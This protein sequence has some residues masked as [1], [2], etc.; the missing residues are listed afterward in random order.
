MSYSIYRILRSLL[1]L[2]RLCFGLFGRRS[3]VRHGHEL[4]DVARNFRMMETTITDRRD[5]VFY[6]K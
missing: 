2:A 1:L 6:I 3:K 4:C 5:L